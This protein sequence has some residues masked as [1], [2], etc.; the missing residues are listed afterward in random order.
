MLGVVA[1]A[2]RLTGFRS[3][4]S[5]VEGGLGSFGRQSPQGF[6]VLLQKQ[7]ALI[8][9]LLPSAAPTAS[10]HSVPQW[11]DLPGRTRAFRPL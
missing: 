11:V 8:E 2:D 5:P 7:K 10:R 3:P 1:G 9:V 6:D 4:G